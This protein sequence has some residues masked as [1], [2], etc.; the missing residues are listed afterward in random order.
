MLAETLMFYD[1]VHVAADRSLLVALLQVINPQDFLTLVNSGRVRLSYSKYWHAVSSTNT[2]FIEQHT[3][4]SFARAKTADGKRTTKTDEIREAVTCVMGI[5]RAS[6]KIVEELLKKT[7]F[8]DRSF[9]MG[10]SIEIAHEELDDD[11]F[12]RPAIEALITILVPTF[13]LPNDWRF[14]PLYIGHSVAIDTNLNF[15]AINSEYHKSIPEAHSSITPAYLLAWILSARMDATM[16]ADY[17]SE[18]VTKDEVSQLIRLKI[19][20]L[21]KNETKAC[22]KLIHFRKLCSMTAEKCVKQ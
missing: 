15:T 19:S 18:I 5:N 22:A 17:M 4:I 12:L 2:G 1:K 8:V 6:K 14:K 9:P 7:A 20:A 3:F 13:R 11:D 21:V 16:A 10:R